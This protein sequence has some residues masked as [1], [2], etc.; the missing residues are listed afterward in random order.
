MFNCI[1]TKLL[2]GIGFSGELRACLVFFSYLLSR[3]Y[4]SSPKHFEAQ[5]QDA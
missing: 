4:N 3:D 1:A 2:A 5:E